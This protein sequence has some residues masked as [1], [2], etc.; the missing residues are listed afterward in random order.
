MR[1][2]LNGIRFTHKLL[3]TTP[4]SENQ[5][6]FLE[7]SDACERQILTIIEDMD[8]GSI[9]EG[10]TE[11]S[12]E[13][14]VLGNVLD[15][16]VSQIMILLKERNL[17]LL[18]ET[19][20]EIKTLSLYGDRIRLQLVLSD[21][22]FNVV[23]HASSLGGWV[24]LKIS[25]GIKLVRDGNEFVRLQFR[26]IHPGK[27]LPFTLIQEMNE[28]GNS[29]TTQEGLGLNMSRKL[30]NKMNGR[31]QYVQEHNRSYFLIDLEIRTRK[32]RLKAPQ[33]K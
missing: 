7:T 21:F 30:L 1:N 28:G 2:P 10:S 6:Q 8:S 24:E 5:K 17:Q 12:M 9:D 33:A 4:I 18:H 26:M 23:H 31:V 29:W 16:V 3:E 32:G 19:P 15:T 14:F 27:G 22:L 25:P 20:K 11:L 13:E